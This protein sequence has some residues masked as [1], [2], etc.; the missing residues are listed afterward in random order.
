M[1]F[2]LRRTTMKKL[3]VVLVAGLIVVAGASVSGG[4]ASPTYQ[5]DVTSV[6]QLQSEQNQ[7]QNMQGQGYAGAGASASISTISD[8]KTRTPPISMFPHQLPYWTHGGWGTVTAY[9]PNGPNSD[10]QVYERR[11]N[12]GDPDDMRELRSVLESLS[13]EGPLNA[14]GGILNGVGVAFG[15][16]DNF[17]HGRGFE[18]A[19]SLV[20]TPRPRRKPL[21]VFIDSNVDRNLL[22]EAGYAYVGKVSLEG[23]VNRNWDH[24]YDAAVAETLPWDVDILLVSGGMKGVTIGSNATFPVAGGAYTQ[25]NYSLSLLGGVSSG[26][27][28]GKGKALVS[29]EGYRYW[30]AVVNRRR[31]P[32]YLYDRIRLTAQKPQP[33]PDSAKAAQEVS[34]AK[35]KEESPGIR[36]SQEL[37]DLAGFE[38]GQR[39]DYITIK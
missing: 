31:I 39:V 34:P 38:E 18:I 8:Y 7:M 11:F 28:E 33:T 10:D 15:G 25:L 14:L 35:T 5:T 9:F 23:K 20:R 13:Y 21:L 24:V 4:T 2:L 19:N 17:H 22:K 37:F 3:I 6:N 36:V 29:A 16:P 30:P 26:I 32:E 12:P 1:E 27:T